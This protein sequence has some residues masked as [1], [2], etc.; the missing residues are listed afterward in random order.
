VPLPLSI[1]IIYFK[2]K[3]PARSMMWHYDGLT[4]FEAMIRWTDAEIFDET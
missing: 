4:S 2:K 3:K 1:A